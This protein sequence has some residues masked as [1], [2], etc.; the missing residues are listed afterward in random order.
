[1]R[2]DGR[3]AIVHRWPRVVSHVS[4]PCARRNTH[5]ASANAPTHDDGQRDPRTAASWPGTLP[6]TSVKPNAF[7]RSTAG[8]SERQVPGARRAVALRDQQ[9]LQRHEPA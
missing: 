6:A 4:T 5:A 7:F 8:L 3:C 1:M 9:F 2:D